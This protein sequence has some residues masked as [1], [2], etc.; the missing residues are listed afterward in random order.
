MATK[1]K[2]SKK[3]S[4]G[5]NQQRATPLRESRFGQFEEWREVAESEGRT[6]ANWVRVTLDNAV[7]KWRKS[8]K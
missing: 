7:E 3:P 1:K 2:S 6:L 4:G 8:K 5:K